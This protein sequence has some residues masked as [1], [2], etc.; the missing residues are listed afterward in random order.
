MELATRMSSLEFQRITA[1]CTAFCLKVGA[2]GGNGI[3]VEVVIRQT[4]IRG[5]I[6]DG[7]EQ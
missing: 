7:G 3:K 2:Q 4:F 1:R 6:T 5:V